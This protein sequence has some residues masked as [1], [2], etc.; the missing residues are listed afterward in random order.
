MSNS[1]YSNRQTVSFSSER[2]TWA[3]Q[4]LILLNCLV[5]VC[6]L[7]VDVFFGTAPGHGSPGGLPGEWLSFNQAALLQGMVWQP[8]T[9]MFLH[10]SLTHLFFNMLWLFFFGP[11]VE[12]ALGT[13]QFL[14]FYVLCGSLSVLATYVP[15][16]L[17]AHLVSVV[18]AS[19]AV[20]GI[21]VAY[22]VLN[23][24]KR[25]FL[26]PLPIEVTATT[27]VLIV[28]AMNILNAFQGGGNTS[29][30]THLGGMAV[31]YAY[32][33][34][35]PQMRSWFRSMSKPPAAKK[36]PMDKLGEE[37]DNILKFEDWKRKR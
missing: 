11:S 27:L 36:G 7:V 8:F 20:M 24:E 23:P 32:M 3:V 22:A 14:W 1:F 9:Y 21:V 30:A 25:F 18:G 28:L 31:G 12:R 10:G 37:V 16:L 19:G 34:L 6:Q 4:R 5:F 2:I 15:T 26:F 35:T 33:K 17:G 13:R 29:V